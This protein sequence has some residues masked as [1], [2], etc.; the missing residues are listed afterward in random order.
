[1]DIC[2]ESILYET[3]ADPLHRPWWVALQKLEKA[4]ASADPI[5]LFGFEVAGRYSSIFKLGHRYNT[6]KQIAETLKN[7]VAEASSEIESAFETRDASV[8]GT[9]MTHRRTMAVSCQG[10]FTYLPL[11]ETDVPWRDELQWD[12]QFVVPA[13]GLQ[14]ASEQVLSA[15]GLNQDDSDGDNAGELEWGVEEISAGLKEP[16][17]VEHQSTEGPST[18]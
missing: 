16:V 14:A 18:W 1:M 11:D 7:L 3:T 15:Y 17:T 2:L 10:Y 6:R 8:N 4:A 13:V 9:E 5:R 12:S